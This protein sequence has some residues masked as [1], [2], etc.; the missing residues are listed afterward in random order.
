MLIIGLDYHPSFQQI[1]Y[2]DT[3]TG[4]CGERRLGHP[5]E[6]EGFYR[7]LRRQHS[8]VRIAMEASGLYN[9]D[10]ESRLKTQ[11]WQSRVHETR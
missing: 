2:L 1:A 7:E 4:E 6:A 9:A 3:E 10:I 8:Q 5:E 11:Y